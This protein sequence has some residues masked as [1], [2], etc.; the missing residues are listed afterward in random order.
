MSLKRILIVEDDS[1]TRLAYHI[2]LKVKQYET[3]FA[4]DPL[5]CLWEAHKNRPELILMDIGLTA[6]DGF[7]AMEQLKAATHLASIPVIVVSGG[8]AQRLEPRA[9][10]SGAKA[11]LQ[12]PVDQTKLLALISNLIGESAG[13]TSQTD[14]S[15]RRLAQANT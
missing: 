2:F 11:Y 14:G 13:E 5:S 10:Q 4:G 1:D 8:D 15:D 6:G 12:K 9:L 3:F 7:R